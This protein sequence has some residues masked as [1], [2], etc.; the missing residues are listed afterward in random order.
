MSQVWMSYAQ[1]EMS[2]TDEGNVILASQVYDR[3][4]QSL[5]GANEKEER[6]LL[7]EAWRDFETQ[8][9]DN[10]S[11]E[12]VMQKMPRRVKKRQRV[13]ADDGVS[14]LFFWYRAVL[15]NWWWWEVVQWYVYLGIYLFFSFFLSFSLSFFLNNSVL[16]M[17]IAL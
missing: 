1:F 7:L 6:V 2:A 3:A 12:K 17:L 11:L 13:H 16:Q 5:R 14:Y 15:F 9:G 10:E 8:H 4:N